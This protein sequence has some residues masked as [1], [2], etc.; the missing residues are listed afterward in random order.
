MK[1]WQTRRHL[2]MIA[3]NPVKRA[4][5]DLARYNRLLKRLQNSTKEWEITWIFAWYGISSF[6]DKI[7]YIHLASGSPAIHIAY[8][9]TYSLK[10]IYK[11]R[12]AAFLTGAWKTNKK[13]REFW[14]TQ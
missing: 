4:N 1:A 3:K 7:D 14:Q 11:L 10:A 12:V 2:K 5:R 8:K 9:D 6:E 13:G